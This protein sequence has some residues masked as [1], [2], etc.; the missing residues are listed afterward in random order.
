MQLDFDQLD[1]S[2]FHKE[3]ASKMQKPDEKLI[4]DKTKTTIKN[5]NR[6]N[7]KNKYDP[8]NRYAGSNQKE[9]TLQVEET[10]NFSEEGE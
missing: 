1:F 2:E 8:A 9:P 6:G 5:I 10:F 3:L 4:K 7:L